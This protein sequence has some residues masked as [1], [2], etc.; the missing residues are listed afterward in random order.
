MQSTSEAP[1]ERPLSGAARLV[2]IGTTAATIALFY[3]YISVAILALLLWLGL[4]L[5]FFLALARFGLGGLIIQ[6]VE[7]DIRLLGLLARS[8]WL[9]EGATYRLPLKPTDAPR[10]FAMVQRLAQRLGIPPPDELCLEMSCGAWVELR[11]LKTGLGTTRVG[12]GYDLLAGL[13][14]RQIEAVMAHELAHAKLIGRFFNNW[15]SRGLGRAATISN[16]LSAT[17]DACRRSNEAFV[18]GGLILTGADFLTRLCARQMGAY[19]RQGEFEADRGAAQLCG[20]AAM[21]SALQQLGVLHPRSDRL[22]W[23]ERVAQI[24]SPEGLSGWLLQE[25]TGTKDAVNADEPEVFDRYSTHPSRRDRLAALSDDGSRLEESPA[26]L[27]LLADPNALALKLVDAIEQTALQQERKDLAELRKWLRT[28]RRS[29]SIRAGQLPGVIVVLFS[30]VF[31]I[32]SLLSEFWIAGLVLL[33]GL[34]PLGVWFY[35][36]GRYRDQRSFPVPDY[37][38]FMKARQN[39]PLPDIDTRQKQIEE[40][41]RTALANETKKKR[42]AARL[43]DE[44]Y[45]ALGR[46]D[47]LRAHV[48]ARLARESEPKSIEAGLALVVATAAFGQND[49]FNGLIN[50]TLKQTA[51]RTPST[52]LAVAWALMLN[53]DWMQAEALLHETLKSRPDHV[54]L[55][56]MLAF[57]QSRR[58]KLQSAIENIRN[59]CQPRPPTDQH[60]KLF[61][62]LLLDRGA[63]REAT[64]RLGEFGPASAYDPEVVYLRVQVCLLRRDFAGAEL[65]LAMLAESELTGNRLLSLGYLY[66]SARADAKALEFFQRALDRGHN[67]EALLAL[68]RHANL[69]KDKSRARAHIHAALDT[70]KTTDDRI[71]SAHDVLP[72]AL[73]QL[74]ELEDPVASCRAWITNFLPGKDAGPLTRRSLMVYAPTEQEAGEYLRS[75]LVA[76]MPNVPPLADA[77]MNIKAAPQDLQ[78]VRPVR[79]GIQYI[80]Q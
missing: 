35:R 41:L 65:Q 15:L 47:Y 76:L 42:L 55:R 14:E 74:V 56:A 29:A 38:V 39:F 34:V 59:C 57:S 19:S 25:L 44:A 28:V 61:V 68:G 63:L 7:R 48:A 32:V 36:L 72:R 11:G 23:N 77:Y 50:F 78:P 26:G 30:F 33:L 62:S 64:E 52:T 54:H 24:E 60:L 67:P 37:E 69:A 43:T 17:A 10:L 12:V 31:G 20:S 40:E 75:L 5:L 58:G 4:V 79:P 13:S 1:A 16:R 8:L 80:Y 70:T 66:E 9:S 3:L 18:A 51:L 71:A 49:T 27:S 22:P 2:L 53:A 45:A 73:A 6:F 46:V 21:R